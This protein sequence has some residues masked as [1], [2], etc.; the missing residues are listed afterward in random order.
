MKLN[1][2]F[3]WSTRKNLT[4]GCLILLTC[5]IAGLVVLTASPIHV[6]NDGAQYLSTI[7]Q[8]LAGN[9]LRTST[10]YYDI[11]AQFGMPAYQ[12]V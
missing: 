11:Q 9:G 8:I 1:M 4:G 10:I 7:D 12:T 2:R 6:S 3:N 5:L